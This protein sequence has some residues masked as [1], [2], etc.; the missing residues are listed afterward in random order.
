MD[1]LFDLI[2]SAASNSFPPPTFHPQSG[3]NSENT[4]TPLGWVPKINLYVTEDMY[5]IIFDV[6]GINQSNIRVNSGLGFVKISGRRT[7]S[8]LFSCLSNT[9]STRNEW[10]EGEFERTFRLPEDS[11]I[12]N[13]SSHYN[14]GALLVKVP[15][16]T[17][18]HF[19]NEIPISNEE[20]RS[21]VE[22]TSQQN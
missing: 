22:S 7:V 2:S 6:S 18:S 4:N 12:S 19:T 3:D 15:R 13:I 14:R 17:T 21:L 1:R 5:Y 11:N 9:T 8:E 20:V 16:I 10:F